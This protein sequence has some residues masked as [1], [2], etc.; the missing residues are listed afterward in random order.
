M[1][2]NNNGDFIFDPQKRQRYDQ[3]GHQGVSGGPG[4]FQDLTDMNDIFRTL[5]D[6]SAAAEVGS[7][8][9]EFFGGGRGSSRK[10]YKETEAEAAI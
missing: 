10:S 5:G 6:I 4:G 1:Q 7:I 8:F 9:E 3:F 2:I